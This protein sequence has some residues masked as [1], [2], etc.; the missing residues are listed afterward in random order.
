MKVKATRGD[1]IYSK[2]DNLR[3]E[4]YFRK[5]DSGCNVVLDA[6]LEMINRNLDL[7]YIL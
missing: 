3:N 7:K 2:N 1:A 5:Y 4:S 6:E